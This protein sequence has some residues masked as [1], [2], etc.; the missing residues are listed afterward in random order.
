M[1]SAASLFCFLPTPATRLLIADFGVRRLPKRPSPKIPRY[2]RAREGKEGDP[3]LELVWEHQS[4][5]R[6]LYQGV[7]GAQGVLW[8]LLARAKLPG[9]PRDDDWEGVAK[10]IGWAY[11]MWLGAITGGKLS[12]SQAS[13]KKSVVCMLYTIQQVTCF[14]HFQSHYQADM[15][16]FQNMRLRGSQKSLRLFTLPLTIEY[17]V[18]SG[19]GGLRRVRVSSSFW[20]VRIGADMVTVE[21]GSGDLQWTVAQYMEVVSSA[22]QSIKSWPAEGRKLLHPML[23][24]WSEQPTLEPITQLRDEA[25]EVCDDSH[26]GETTQVVDKKAMSGGDSV[27]EEEWEEAVEAVEAAQE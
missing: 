23:V 14:V 22:K 24:E 16:G 13:T 12:P 4:L 3:P 1:H 25:G 2:K 18:G 27:A 5:W 10:S 11:V 6:P 15:L 26:D 21:M 20:E 9:V 17:Q 19:N 7:K 8:S